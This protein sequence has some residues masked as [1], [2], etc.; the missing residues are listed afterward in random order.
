VNCPEPGCTGEIDSD[1]YCTVSGMKVSTLADAS[2]STTT[3]VTPVAGTPSG[4]STPTGTTDASSTG[5][6][7]S[8][9][10]T[11]SSPRN[12]LGAGL[13]D[14][15]AI[16]EHDPAQA[17]LDDPTVPESKR[18][19]AIDGE[20]VGRSRDGVPGRIEGFCPKCGYRFSFRPKLEPGDVVGG[21]YEV[22]GCL[23][24]GGLGWIYLAR[25][26]KL[27]DRWVVLK[28]LLNT[29][30]ADALTAALAERRFLAQVEHPD[31]VKIFNFAEHGSDGYIVMEYVGG[32][33][34]RG[35]LEQHRASDGEPLPV[36]HA[37]AYMHD[38][39]PALGY[40]HRRGLLFCDFKP[41]NVMQRGTALTL[42]DLG[43]VYRMGDET[44]PMY[45]TKG[46]QAPEI[47]ST[48]PTVPSDLF[49]VGR[50]LAVLC[51]NFR[52]YQKKYE[53]ML[54]PQ[55]E[56]PVYTTYDSLYRFLQ[57]ATALDSDDRFQ[58]AEEM[59]DQLY[60]VL[61]EV[62]AH[63]TGRPAL[64]PSTLF[65][66][67]LRGDPKRPD[68]HK[69]PALLV[70][71]DDPAAGFL[72]L[73]TTTARDETS[74]LAELEQ[75]PIR[76]VEVELRYA[77]ALIEAG[78]HAD[79]EKVLATIE[80]EDE[81]E[82][83][84]AWYRGL[85]R[86][87]LNEPESAF[88]EFSVVYRTVPGELAAKLALA[89]AAEGAGRS[90]AA[91]QWYDVV[92]RTDPNFTSAAFGLARC[93]Q[94]MG[95]HGGSVAA[96]DRVPDTSSAYVEAQV[97]KVERLLAANGTAAIGDV[98]AAGT[99]IDTLDLVDEAQAR[100]TAQVLSAA[101][102]FV[103]GNGHAADDTVLMGHPLTEDGVRR[104]LE[105]TYRVLARHAHTG[106]DRISF[107]DRANEVRPRTL[108]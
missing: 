43:G 80:T 16:P 27:E 102:P 14:I 103:S 41:D 5:R 51:T 30:D 64:G 45:G 7:R 69:L 19:C 70:S 13:L 6:R 52:G 1:G 63:Q 54:P 88:E 68:W 17:V 87:S 91:A 67:E 36:A 96:Y 33:S 29:G 106:E 72:A 20:P 56:I 97:A 49:T 55:E 65:S 98:V 93:L 81:W 108:V 37:I 58:S 95:D 50:T 15:P 2:R 101:L 92:S 18:F 12:R 23:A 100:L 86:L 77:R 22:V 74:L 99:I 105:A 39:L 32:Q 90:A 59:A 53:F 34:L 21:Q 89:Y 31:I 4:T 71:A 28:G 66:N 82:W 104:R 94:E 42:I 24:H 40:L 44:S 11:S 75:A 9:S 38:I 26:Q 73:L 62:V 83:R 79:A 57:R 85:M 3:P 60:G 25:D 10:R 8:T 35:L 61:R 48:G 78:R 84:V 46:Y 76:S 47:S 107:V